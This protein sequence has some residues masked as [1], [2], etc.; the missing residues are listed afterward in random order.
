VGLGTAV[1]FGQTN[2]GGQAPEP[3][4]GDDEMR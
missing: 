2:P 3:Y 1:P 4:K